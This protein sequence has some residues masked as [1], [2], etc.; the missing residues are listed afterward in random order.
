MAK[1]GMRNKK[2]A[3]ATPS[4]GKALLKIIAYGAA[5]GAILIAGS[6]K[7]G[8]TFLNENNNSKGDLPEEQKGD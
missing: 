1:V 5:G 2:K 6:K 4:L 3:A 8:E 7:A